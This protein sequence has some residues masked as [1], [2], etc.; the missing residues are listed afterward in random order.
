MVFA[1]RLTRI[2][3]VI[4]SV[5]KGLSMKKNIITLSMLFLSLG[6]YAYESKYPQSRE[7]RQ[8]DE[9]GS[10]L[11]GEGII[12]RPS[13]I[14]NEST[15]TTHSTFNKY[16]WDASLDVLSVA[17]LMVK[18]ENSGMI[19]TDWYSDKKDPNLTIKVSVKILDNII[20]PESIDVEV[21]QRVFKNGRWLE[22]NASDSIKIKT[23]EE[24]LRKAKSLY[25]KKL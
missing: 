21:L 11:G 24:I 20:A 18:D 23:E 12:F 2:I 5:V 6:A 9:M 4:I 13:K 22:D 1:S 8:A 3:K 25:A 15:K 10:I 7:D 19:S 17:P 16:L 14:R